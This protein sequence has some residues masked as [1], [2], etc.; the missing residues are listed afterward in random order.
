[1]RLRSFPS[2]KLATKS[3]QT[4]S[5]RYYNELFAYNFVP[6]QMDLNHVSQNQKEK[7][8]LRS[9]LGTRRNHHRKTKRL[10]DCYSP[11]KQAL[12]KILLSEKSQIKK[13]ET[14]KASRC[15]NI[16]TYSNVIYKLC[17]IM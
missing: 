12:F 10:E 4:W 7:E 17:L 2:R 5:Q 9:P 6:A 13:R 16:F 8:K 3:L 14:M 1:M 11:R 15:K